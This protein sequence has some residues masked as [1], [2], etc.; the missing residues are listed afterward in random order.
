MSEN[1]EA[2][3]QLRNRLWTVTAAWVTCLVLLPGGCVLAGLLTWLLELLLGHRPPDAIMFVGIGLSFW[4]LV[5]A[6]LLPR[7]RGRIKR[8]LALAHLA[9]QLQ[10]R[11]SRFPEPDVYALVEPVLRPFG[12]RHHPSV[13]SFLSGPPGLS[14]LLRGELHGTKVYL[15]DL[16]IDK[17][18]IK[19]LHSAMIFPKADLPDFTLSKKW[20]KDQVKEKDHQ[21]VPLGNPEFDEAFA[22]TGRQPEIVATCFSPTVISLLQAQPDLHAYSQL[23]QVL[24]HVQGLVDPGQCMA[25]MESSTR[26]VEALRSSRSRP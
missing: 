22:L 24:I 1:Q 17:I 23:G 13:L 14:N 19:W 5:G 2:I 21:P 8:A 26:F 25:F 11:Y 16:A 6:W 20:T 15:V 4:S 9:D 12:A 10:F 18:E 7:D 3:A